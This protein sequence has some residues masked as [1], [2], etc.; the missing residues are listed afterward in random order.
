MSALA[1]V[2]PDEPART[3]SRCGT[4]RREVNGSARGFLCISC[5]LAETTPT[6]IEPKDGYGVSSYLPSQP[7]RLSGGAYGSLGRAQDG[8]AG[9]RFSDTAARVRA[10][11]IDAPL[12]CSF[13]CI[14]LGHDHAARLHPATGFWRYRCYGAAEGF[15][16]AEV[17]AYLAYDGIRRISPVEAVRWRERLDHEAGLLDRDPV[18][19]LVPKDAPSAAKRIA[20]GI[21]LLV[22]LRSPRWPQDEPFPFA[23]DFA[24]AYCGVSDDV[25][26]RGVRA[27]EALGLIERAGRSGRAILWRLPERSRAGSG[28]GRG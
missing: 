24:R 15:G 13:A 18:G 21:G 7:K 23:R 22:G 19:L 4:N 10:L 3:C 6:P 11:G 16:V 5:Y 8:I 9:A 1:L 20:S 12:G 27:L 17:R 14:L 25:A 26:R 2:I 28:A